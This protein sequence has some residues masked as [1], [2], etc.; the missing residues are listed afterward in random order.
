MTAMCKKNTDADDK[1]YPDSLKS[2]QRSERRIAGNRRSIGRNKYPR[3]DTLD[4]L[5][6]DEPGRMCDPA[7]SSRKDLF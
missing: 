4:V 6:R 1:G 5:H 3:N 2:D 7:L